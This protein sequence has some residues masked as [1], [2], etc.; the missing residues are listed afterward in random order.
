MATFVHNSE[1]DKMP[2]DQIQHFEK[3]QPEGVLQHMAHEIHEAWNEFS[4]HNGHIRQLKKEKAGDSESDDKFL[5][6]M[7]IKGEDDDNVIAKKKD[8]E[9]GDNVVIKKKEAASHSVSDF[10]S[11]EAYSD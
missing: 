4:G 9:G 6:K 5:P 1:G 10:E 2:A 3:K 11:A 7:S 8:A